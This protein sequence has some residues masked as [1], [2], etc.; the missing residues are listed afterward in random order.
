MT[1]DNRYC[2]K[3]GKWGQVAHAGTVNVSIACSSC[4]TRWKVEQGT[5]PHCG[6][7]NKYATDGTC[8]ECYSIAKVER[9]RKK[10]GRE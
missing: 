2:P 4:K 5:C 3:C 9:D 7:M 6:K 8:L 10:G 1:T